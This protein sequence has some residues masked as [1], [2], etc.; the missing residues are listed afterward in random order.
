MNAVR[1]SLAS[2][3]QRTLPA[4]G[5]PGRV[6]FFVVLFLKEVPLRRTHMT[7]EEAELLAAEAEVGAAGGETPQGGGAEGAQEPY[8]TGRAGPAAEADRGR[9]SGRR[10]AAG[11]RERAHEAG[12]A[13][14]SAAPARRPAA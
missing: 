5:H 12:G 6:G 9:E 4:G 13:F 14:A 1:V 11:C 3:H 2:A 7:V 8:I 10:A